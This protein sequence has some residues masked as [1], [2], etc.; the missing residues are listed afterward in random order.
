MRWLIKA[1]L[2]GFEADL[3]DDACDLRDY[4]GN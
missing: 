1:I 4:E 2:E 3:L